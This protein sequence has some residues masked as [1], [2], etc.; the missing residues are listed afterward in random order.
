[1]PNRI[2]KT[3]PIFVFLG[4]TES[5][6][7]AKISVLQ[8]KLEKLLAEYNQ[9]I[10]IE[11]KGNLLTLTLTN[12]D[13][14][15]YVSLVKNNSGELPYWIYLAKNFKLPWDKKPVTATRLKRIYNFLEED[16]KSEYN[17]FHEIGFTI[18]NEL[19]KFTQLKVFTIPSVEKRTL[20]D[21]LFHACSGS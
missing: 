8:E 14:C 10:K 18:L 15:F 6:T 16:G 17:V 11:L 7:D 1:M 3:R 9:L 21:K 4:V 5:G 19:E 2:T 12:P 20:W 13:F